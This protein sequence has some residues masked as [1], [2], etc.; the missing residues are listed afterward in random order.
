M[1][2]DKNRAFEENVRVVE[3]ECAIILFKYFGRCPRV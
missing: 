3:F 2:A 1:G